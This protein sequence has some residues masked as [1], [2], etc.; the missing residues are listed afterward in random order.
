MGIKEDKQSLISSLVEEPMVKEDSLESG[1]VPR[2][3]SNNNSAA[4]VS[5]DIPS[6]LDDSFKVE[7]V[8]CSL[9]CKYRSTPP[10]KMFLINNNS[11]GRHTNSPE[12]P[13]NIFSFY[14]LVNNNGWFMTIK[15]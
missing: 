5:I 6:F 4:H 10:R 3:D 12:I 13:N 14:R 1:P 9:N 8:S 7:A 15:H 11:I 2:L